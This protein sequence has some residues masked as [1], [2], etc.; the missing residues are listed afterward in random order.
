MV[1]DII[2]ISRL[3]LLTGVESSLLFFGNITFKYRSG[4]GKC[5]EMMDVNG[6]RLSV[7]VYCY[8]MQNVRIKG[9]EPLTNFV[10]YLCFVMALYWIFYYWIV[11]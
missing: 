3:A 1:T 7:V 9:T 5:M 4:L 6:Y 8:N 10:K 11:N 2:T